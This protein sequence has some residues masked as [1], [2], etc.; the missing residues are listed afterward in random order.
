MVAP[1]ANATSPPPGVPTTVA[2]PGANSLVPK[3][4]KTKKDDMIESLIGGVD[5]I[6]SVSAINVENEIKKLFGKV[7]YTCEIQ[8]DHT[9]RLITEE[10]V[11]YL[12]FMQV[13]VWKLL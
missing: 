5:N 11:V 12:L 3:P 9:C 4:K 7:I 2:P 1:I 8:S 13:M 10:N 6:E